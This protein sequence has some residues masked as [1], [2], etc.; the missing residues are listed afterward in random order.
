MPSVAA[1]EGK[2]NLSCSGRNASTYHLA[3]MPLDFARFAC[4]YRQ[5]HKGRHKYAAKKELGA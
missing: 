3:E 4:Y 1:A 5:Q 2:V